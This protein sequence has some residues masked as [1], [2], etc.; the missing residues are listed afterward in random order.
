MED[1]VRQQE[2]LMEDRVRQQE[3]PGAIEHSNGEASV[4]AWH[5]C[6]R[7]LLENGAAAGWLLQHGATMCHTCQAAGSVAALGRCCAASISDPLAALVR[8]IRHLAGE[9]LSV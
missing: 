6:S 2:G 3:E 8:L 4:G 7:G 5:C 1:R 9:S